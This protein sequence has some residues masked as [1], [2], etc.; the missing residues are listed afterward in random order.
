MLSRDHFSVHYWFYV[1]L[2]CLERNSGQFKSISNTH[3]ISDLGE[4]GGPPP[5]FGRGGEGPP[6]FGTPGGPPRFG[7][8]TQGR[9]PADDH[10]PGFN[11]P[12]GGPGGF[13]NG[14]PP[15]PNGGPPFRDGP[16][17]FGAANEAGGPPF[18]GQ[19]FGMRDGR[20]NFWRGGR[21]AGHNLNN[22]TPTTLLPKCESF[23]YLF[24]ESGWT[25]VLLPEDLTASTDSHLRTKGDYK[26]LIFKMI[27]RAK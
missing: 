27:T 2:F 19:D 1:I 11:G 13:R 12:P 15:F 26:L 3:S 14:P 4:R 25:K 7:A 21:E 23:F 17:P 20:G 6:P 24:Q 8:H 18:G 9:F 10:A 16:P 22:T 5:P